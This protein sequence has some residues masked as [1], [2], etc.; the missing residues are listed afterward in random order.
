M[1]LLKYWKEL[2]RTMFRPIE[3]FN[4][5][6]G[7]QMFKRDAKIIITPNQKKNL[8]NLFYNAPYE[9]FIIQPPQ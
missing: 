9:K 1:T 8:F 2:L 6:H 7:G 5:V 3:S 4:S